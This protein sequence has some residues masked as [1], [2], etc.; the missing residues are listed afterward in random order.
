MSEKSSQKTGILQ[1]LISALPIILGF[2]PV[3]FAYGVLA[4]KAGLSAFNIM[5][6]S[7][8]VFA[9][10]SQF[11]AVGLFTAGAGPLTIIITTFAV[12]I[13]HFIM[14]SSLA[15]SLKTFTRLEQA[16]FAF[17]ITDE[18]FAVHSLNFNEKI[19]DKARAF[20]TNI[21][22][23]VSWVTGSWLGITIGRQ[24]P[25]VKVFALDFALPGMFAAL[26]ILSI[27]SRSRILSAVLSGASA[28]ILLNLGLSHW[29]IILAAFIGATAGL[30]V[31]TWTRQK[32]S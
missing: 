30:G 22:A 21:S 12:N 16:L 9:G 27:S 15:K 29:N 5:A 18:T 26:L 3:G 17:Q 10:A 28:L 19:P 4:D 11:I 14:A 23:Q 8:I 2:V 1:G 31:K 24:I 20:T 25:D 13:R 6:M 7:I 32:S